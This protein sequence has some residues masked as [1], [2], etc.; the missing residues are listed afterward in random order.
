MQEYLAGL[1]HSLK[2][3]LS[4]SLL[5]YRTKKDAA[6]IDDPTFSPETVQVQDQLGDVNG[7]IRDTKIPFITALEDEDT[8]EDL[9][10][11]GVSF[12]LIISSWL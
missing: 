6:A 11:F 2:R 8:P 7:R 5:V 3:W 10:V 9:E 4:N 12:N 1:I